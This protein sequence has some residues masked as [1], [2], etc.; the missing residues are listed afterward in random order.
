[1]WMG[2]E[3]RVERNSAPDTLSNGIFYRPS[4]LLRR[5]KCSVSNLSIYLSI[6]LYLFFFFFFFCFVDVTIANE[7]PAKKHC[8]PIDKQAPILKLFAYCRRLLDRVLLL[9]CSRQMWAPLTPIFFLL[10]R[11]HLSINLANVIYP[12]HPSI[13]ISIS[14]IHLSYFTLL[15]HLCGGRV[16]CSYPPRWPIAPSSRMSRIL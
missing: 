12:H 15:S 2:N 14:F 5:W 6:Y 3:A 10:E 1:M 7:Y 11:E 8:F 4:M 13:L 16:P 9:I